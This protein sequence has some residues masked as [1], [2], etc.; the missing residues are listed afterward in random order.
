MVATE[1]YFPFDHQS[2]SLHIALKNSM[3]INW[4]GLNY[5]MHLWP[6]S[7]AYTEQSDAFSIESIHVH[8]D[9]FR[10]I[11]L[12]RRGNSTTFAAERAGLYREYSHSYANQY[13]VVRL[14]LARFSSYFEYNL[15]VPLLV[16]VSLGLCTILLPSE[17]VEKPEILLTILLAYTFF[18]VLFA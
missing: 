18:Q 14:E 12:A 5:T 3:A 17:A 6:A 16:I 15:I 1:R 8:L 7:A 4:V 11:F 10:E 13:A 9:T 2:C